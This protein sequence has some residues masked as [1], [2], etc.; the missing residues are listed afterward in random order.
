MS[1][2]GPGDDK[3]MVTWRATANGLEAGAAE[4]CD[5]L[6]PLD[7]LS[8]ANAREA[9]ESVYMLANG[10]GKTRANRGGGGRSRRSWRIFFL[11]SGE[12][13]LQAKLSEAGQRTRAGQDVRMIELPADPGA[14]M[15]VWQTLH[16][17][18]SAAEFTNHLRTAA[19]MY[20]GT[21][22][23]EYLI[24]LARDRAE[25]AAKLTETLCELRKK[26]LD[27]HVPSNVDGQVQNVAERFVLRRHGCP[28][29]GR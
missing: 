10:T 26:F 6:L 4:R 29:R 27:K 14:G 16:G 20:C 3:H 18:S 12:I 1:V 28:A 19:S 7:E 23:A 17:F 11:S 5:G 9:G 13:S 2:Y 22:G 21:A 24:Q 15:G 8:Q 25:K